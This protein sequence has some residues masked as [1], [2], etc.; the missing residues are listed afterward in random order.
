MALTKVL[1]N[2]TIGGVVQVVNTQSGAVVQGATSIPFDDTIPQQA[3]E[4]YEFLTA[5]ITPTSATNKLK[6]TVVFNGANQSSPS[7]VF[8]LALF[9]DSTANALAAS[10]NATDANYPDRQVTLVYFMTA[11]TTSATTFKV[12]AGNDTG[13]AVTM[14]G[15]NPTAR[16][17]GGVLMSSITIEEI[18][19]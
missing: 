17:L 12:K 11:G 14:N 19:V 8:T 3:T 5:S 18:A 1:G 13:A 15:R 2:M 4:G 6:I 10:V 16:K 9:Q 7:G